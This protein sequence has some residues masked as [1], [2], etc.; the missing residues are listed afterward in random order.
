MKFSDFKR[1]V[2]EKIP[3]RD[4]NTLI[5]K[6]NLELILDIVKGINNSLVI[7]EVL[8]LVIKSAI[9]Q[10][11]TERGFIVLLDKNGKLEYRIGINNSG[12]ILS[13]SDFYISMS[14]VKDVYFTGRSR[15]VESAQSDTNFDLSKSISQLEL[16]T[17]LCSPLINRDNKI[18]VIY[19]DS[20]KLTSLKDREITDTFEILAGQ[21]AIAINNAQMYYEQLVAYQE[22]KKTFNELKKAK[23][24]AERSDKLKSEFLAQMSHE[25]RTPINGLVGYLSLIKDECTGK[26]SANLNNC[27]TFMDTAV[28]RII[29]TVD[30]ILNMSEVQTGSYNP[31]FGSIE[32]IS[33]I[34]KIYLD[35][36][37]IAEQ[38]NIELSLIKNCD[39]ALVYGDDYSINQ[40][41]SHII[42]NAIKFTDKGKIEI[43]VS[44]NEE[45][46]YVLRIIDSGIGISEKFLPQIFNPFLQEDQGYSRKYEGNGL[47]LAL[48]K[49]FCEINKANIEITSQKGV[50]TTCTVIFNK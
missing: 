43:N 49:K 31:N 42:D 29:R 2:N 16:Q 33:I 14:V 20:K 18:G 38:K 44:E 37:P 9:D 28:K 46:N 48:V 17:I 4:A 30:E 13:E 32:I 26:L 35:Y 36:S 8:T 47:G 22:L 5:R 24:V 10:T 39:N 7:Q 34:K 19:V 11:N 21:A 25:I 12:D 50:G 41:I 23:E 45:G 15:F 27:F 6:K 40:I 1:Q 3:V